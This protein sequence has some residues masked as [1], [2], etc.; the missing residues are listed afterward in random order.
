MLKI[1]TIYLCY[2]EGDYCNL[3]NCSCNFLTGP[4]STVI[5]YTIDSSKLIE[6][7]QPMVKFLPG[8]VKECDISQLLIFYAT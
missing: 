2:I 8:P 5:Q 4:Y 6:L 1:N 7:V 3:A